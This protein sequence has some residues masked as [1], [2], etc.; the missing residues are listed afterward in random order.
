MRSNPDNF[1]L[2]EWEK[3]FKNI[4]DFV[5]YAEKMGY[6]G[7]VL[8]SWST[9]GAYSYLY[10]AEN[11]L[12]DLQ[13]IRHVYPLTGFNILI[14]AYL[15]SLQGPLDIDGFI[16]NYCRDRFGFT[17]A[18]ARTFQTALF[19]DSPTVTLHP[20]RGQTEFDHYLLMMAIHAEYLAFREIERRANQPDADPKDL[21]QNL[22]DLLDKDDS[23]L[24]QK[25]IELNQGSYYLSELKAENDL[26]TEKMR[27]LYD[28]LTKNR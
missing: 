27:L 19:A 4:R 14:A 28:R 11:D 22:H 6:Q 2:T 20:L 25:F 8:T 5:P 26:R 7:I 12:L 15:A 13:A 9:S 23:V 16:Q 24:A 1:Y 17:P 18:Q 10:E 21:A 3:H